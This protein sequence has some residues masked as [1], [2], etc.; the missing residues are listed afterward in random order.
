MTRLILALAVVAFVAFVAWSTRR[1]RRRIGKPR[2][3]AG[4][5]PLDTSLLAGDAHTWVVFTTEF[6]ASCQP[7]VDRLRADHPGD[8]VVT[9]DVADRPDLARRYDIRRAPT[10]MLAAPDGAVL[11]LRARNGESVPAPAP[12]SRS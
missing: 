2:D 12:Q 1:A 8:R 5:P 9:L 3:V 10:V 6:C 7:T 4:L 11:E